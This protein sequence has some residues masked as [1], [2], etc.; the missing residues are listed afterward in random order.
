MGIK[1]QA[2]IKRVSPKKLTDIIE[3]RTPLGLFLTKEGR[4]WVAVD[5]TTEDAWT[6]EF[7]CKRQAVHWLRGKFEVSD[8][9]AQWNR[10][11]NAESLI[12]VATQQGITLTVANADMILGYFEGHDY[13]LMVNS[14]G[15]T[16]RHD[17][18]YGDNHRED[19]PYTMYEVVE[20]CQ[21]MNAE[22]LREE[23]PAEEYLTQ[24]RK[25]EKALSDLMARLD[26][27]GEG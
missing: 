19:E 1:K 18:Q 6:E 8:Q 17:E 4:I 22:L 24:L 3:L 14:G 21:E 11:N 9:V 7:S 16:M 13:C 5:N 26:Y 20:F 2:H 12:M 27:T 15:Q 10:I 25:D 23:R